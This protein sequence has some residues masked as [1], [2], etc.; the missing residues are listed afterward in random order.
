MDPVLTQ[1]IQSAAGLLARQKSGKGLPPRVLA[2]D[3]EI[4]VDAELIKK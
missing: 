2:V 3:H 1:L 4:T